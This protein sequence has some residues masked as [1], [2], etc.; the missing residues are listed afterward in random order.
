MISSQYCK[1]SVM[2]K[3]AR[4]S[5]KN[6]E[7]DCLYVCIYLPPS[8]MHELPECDLHQILHRPPHCLGEG[9]KH[10]YDPANLIPWPRGTPNS[11][12]QTDHGTKNFALEKKH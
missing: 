3:F 9:S 1:V 4:H 12:T 2:I 11:K 10:K 8:F 7:I 6:I 5:K